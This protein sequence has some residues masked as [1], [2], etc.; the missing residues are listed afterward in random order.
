M[1]KFNIDKQLDSN[2]TV[3]NN[4]KDIREDNEYLILKKQLKGKPK[5]KPIQFYLSDELLNNIN[6]LCRQTGQKRNDLVVELLKFA[7]SKT[8]VLDE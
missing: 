8:K 1:S 7:I 6:L 5:S 2:D 3:S 4:I